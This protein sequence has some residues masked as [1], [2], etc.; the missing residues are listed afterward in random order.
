MPIRLEKVWFRDK[1]PINNLKVAMKGMIMN[2]R[3]NTN[4]SINTSINI[5][6]NISTNTSMDTNTGTRRRQTTSQ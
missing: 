1:I 3:V 6:T 4:T 5:N 2:I